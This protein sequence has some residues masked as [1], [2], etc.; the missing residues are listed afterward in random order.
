V[1]PLPPE[2]TFSLAQLSQLTQISA[3]TLRY[4]IHIQ[5]LD[6]P[7]GETKGAFYV[8]HHLEQILRIKQLTQAGLSLDR[9]REILRGAPAPLPTPPRQ[10]GHVE[11]RSHLHI[12][13]GIELQVSPDQAQMSPEEMRAFFQELLKAYQSIKG[14]SSHDK[15]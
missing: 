1:K 9:I 7:Q 12:A 11:V 8:G 6:R 15:L 14:V 2:S 10:S 3:R 5:L 4:Y 13:P